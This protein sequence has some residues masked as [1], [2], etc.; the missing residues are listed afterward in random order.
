MIAPRYRRL[1]PCSDPVRRSA[2]SV[3]KLT[4]LTMPEN[5]RSFDLDLGVTRSGV[6][7]ICRSYFTMETTLSS[8]RVIGVGTGLIA[9]RIGG[10]SAG[11]RSII[12]EPPFH[13]MRNAAYS[14]SPGGGVIGTGQSVPVVADIALRNTVR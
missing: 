9:P 5:S 11:D 13:A 10:Q 14:G 4:A 2:V 12:L 7:R 6:A 8:T 1:V 3:A